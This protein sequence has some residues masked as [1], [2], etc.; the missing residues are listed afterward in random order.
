MSFQE[1][2]RQNGKQ[3]CNIS[4]EMKLK[5][6][7]PAEEFNSGCGASDANL[8]AAI[9][10]ALDSEGARFDDDVAA[11]NNMEKKLQSYEVKNG[12]NFTD[13]FDTFRE[14]AKTVRLPRSLHGDGKIS[15]GVVQVSHH[16]EPQM[17]WPYADHILRR[18]TED[19]PTSFDKFDALYGPEHALVDQVCSGSSVSESVVAAFSDDSIIANVYAMSDLFSTCSDHDMDTPGPATLTYL[20]ESYSAHNCPEEWQ[21]QFISRTQ[22]QIPQGFSHE[23]DPDF[24]FIDHYTGK[25]RSYASD[26]KQSVDDIPPMA[27]GTYKSCKL[28]LGA[29][30][31]CEGML[32]VEE[33][34]MSMCNHDEEKMSAAM[35]IDTNSSNNDSCEEEEDEPEGVTKAPKVKAAK[36]TKKP[37]SAKEPKRLRA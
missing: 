36:N 22:T 6:K 33:L 16:M 30:L 19:L 14:I 23:R 37:K 32:A 28:R 3:L 13:S 31:V 20:F 5:V 27:V 1:H 12:M 24:T 18:H 8:K 7:R 10:A 2:L 11:M 21:G 34:S 17:N 29:A 25:A 35:G 26:Y 4:L 9:F 15:L